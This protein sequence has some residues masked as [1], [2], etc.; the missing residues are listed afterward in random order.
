MRWV[1]FLFIL[2]ILMA[3]GLSMISCTNKMNFVCNGLFDS[4]LTMSEKADILKKCSEVQL[5]W[6]KKF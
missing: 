3:I 2:F 4:T 6:R 1:Y 5:T